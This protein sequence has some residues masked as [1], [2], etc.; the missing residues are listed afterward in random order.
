MFEE[1]DLDDADEVN[2][3]DEKKADEKLIKE[4]VSLKRHVTWPKRHGDEAVMSVKVKK[5]HK[6]VQIKDKVVGCVLRQ[7]LH[8]F[9]HY[10]V[11]EFVGYASM[12]NNTGPGHKLK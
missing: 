12:V 6:E 8:Q 9:L 1:F 10:I 3:V 5:E 11:G 7:L 2:V 4:P